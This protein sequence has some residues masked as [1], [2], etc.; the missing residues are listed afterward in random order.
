MRHLFGFLPII[1]AGVCFG[2][3]VDVNLAVDVDL[4]VDADFGVGFVV[5]L[6]FLD[7]SWTLTSLLVLWSS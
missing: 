3:G 1:D 5:G 2:V 6:G 7:R 4:G